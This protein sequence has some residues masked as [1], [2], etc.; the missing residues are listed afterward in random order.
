M[1]LRETWLTRDRLLSYF[2]ALCVSAV[3]TLI[4]V[5][6]PALRST[7]FL[8]YLG[9]IA[10]VARFWGFG[11]AL[12]TIACSGISVDY[13]IFAPSGQLTLSRMD[14]IRITGFVAVSLV[15]VSIARERSR[16]DGRLAKSVE[17][18]NLNSKR[19]ELIE[20]TVNAGTWEFDVATGVS[21]W[22][23]GISAIW[24]LPREPHTIAISEFVTRI[25][26]E[27]RE[28]VG[29]V[30]Q[31]AI[32]SGQPYEVEFRAVWPDG[33]VHW[34]SA[35]GALVHDAQGKPHKIIG[36]AM[37]VTER[38]QAERALRETEKLA[39]A[40][41]L[42]A[43][44]AHEINNPLEAVT[45]LV[46]LAKSDR[47]LSPVTREYLSNADVELRRV[48]H[49]VRQTLGFYRESSHPVWVKLGKIVE[50]LLSLYSKKI[51]SKEIDITRKI[52]HDV[53]VFGFEGELRQVVANLIANAIDAAP[54]GGR[55]VVRLKP[56]RD[57][58]GS[59]LVRLLV[60]DNG[61]GI[62]HE[63]RTRIFQPFFTTK[64]DVGTGLGLWVSKGIVEKHHGRIGV[65]SITADGKSG[66]IFCVELPVAAADAPAHVAASN[67]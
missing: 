26:P 6:L 44:I 45:N 32:A 2:A 35:R 29:E 38:H 13:L 24:G 18:A 8:P 33:S 3:C 16:A 63:H 22:P 48:N 54:P 21:N 9:A 62:V 66:A 64:K 10:L 31:T 30:V 61:G 5:W 50:D 51:N 42:A 56:T 49:I 52:D 41:R 47:S 12:L 39:A 14:A 15:I 4:V 67:S 43:T 46:F 34:L 28:R 37:E 36:I 20:S 17:Q 57:R 25:H 27:D 11:P 7:P 53:A 60:A 1:R 55:I 23:P 58:S 40:G 65:R 19:L 59:Q